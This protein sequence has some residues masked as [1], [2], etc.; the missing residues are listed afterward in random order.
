MITYSA[1]VEYIEELDEYVIPLTDEICEKLGWKKEEK[2][3]KNKYKSDVESL[4]I[5]PNEGYK[6]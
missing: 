3:L 5:E 2:R 4:T 6:K 1:T